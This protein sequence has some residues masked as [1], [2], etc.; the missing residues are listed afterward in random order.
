MGMARLRDQAQ[1]GGAHGAVLSDLEPTGIST[2]MAVRR[3]SKAV[4]IAQSSEVHT[5]ELP[6]FFTQQP[7]P[8]VALVLRERK[9]VAG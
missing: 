9:S 5:V 4:Q 8:M 2:G 1:R 3:V 6:P 7:P